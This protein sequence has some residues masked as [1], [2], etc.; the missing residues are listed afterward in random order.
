MEYRYNFRLLNRKQK[1]EAIQ[2][3]SLSVLNAMPNIECRH[4]LSNFKLPV[5]PCLASGASSGNLM[6]RYF[7]AQKLVP[8]KKTVIGSDPVYTLTHQQYMCFLQAFKDMD[9]HQL[10]EV[11]GSANLPSWINFPG[12]SR[13][14]LLH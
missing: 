13:P 8:V 14:F 11:L 6:Q 1:A 10:R 3:E 5:S 7:C 4:P 12:D 9:V 2:V